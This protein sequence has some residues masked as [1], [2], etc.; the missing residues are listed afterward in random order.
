[1]IALPIPPMLLA[2]CG[3]HGVPLAD[4]AIRDP[5]ILPDTA[6]RTYYLVASGG[7]S[8]TVRASKDL[9]TWSEPQTVFALPEGH[10]GPS[11]IWAPEMHRYRGKYY[12][13]ATFM[14][15]R[16][17]APQRP[18]WPPLV[19]RG[20]Q[21]LVA[22]RPEGP[23]VPFDN[24][25][26]TP[27]DEMALDGTL[28]VEGG[29]PH[30]IYCHEWVQIR[31]GG[32]NLIRLKRDLSASEGEPRVLFRGSDAP[33]APR[34]SERYVTDGPALYR[35]KSGRLFM[36]WSSFSDTGYTTG[37]A[38]SDSGKVAGPWRQQA[39][40]FYRDDG[41]H[42]MIFR[43]FDRKLRVAL[44]APNRSPEERCRIFEVEDTGE[45]LRIV[46]ER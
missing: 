4:I 15:D 40:P 2:T 29:V 32:M 22:D 45:T 10:W 31:D 19:R 28:W 3:E 41:G 7:R 35:S 37:L 18:G 25:P 11:A 5:F 17:L 14:D 12:V 26:H 44:H 8:V 30:M 39:E 16:P 13:F 34:G 1:M 20:T 42:A 24:R 27:D 33:W 43:G 46:A 21:I 6:S 38:V 9:R 36:L 23:F